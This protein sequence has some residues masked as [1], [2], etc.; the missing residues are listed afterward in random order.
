MI[1]K[2]ITANG[3]KGHHKF[4]LKVNEDRT[5]GNS[6]F[7]SFSF[8][9]SPIQT[10]WDWDASGV[11]YYI[12]IGDKEYSG[13]IY[14][15]NG[16]S[17]VTI[18][19]EGGIE[20]PHETDGTK[21]IDIAFNVVDSTSYSFTPG[22]AKASSTL[23]LTK[24]H[25]PPMLSSVSYKE[26]NQQLINVGVGDDYFVTN[27]SV[28]NVT[29]VATP[30]D[31]AQIT[32]YEIINGDKVY[33][34][35]TN[36]VEMNLQENSLEVVY[37]ENLKRNVAK[38]TIRLTDDLGGVSSFAYPYNYV[39]LYTK[40][41][42][43]KTSTTIKRKTGWSEQQQKNLV[44]TD[45]FGVLNFVGTCY[46]GNDVIGNN[47]TPKV[48]YKI[49]NGTEPSYTSLTTSNVANVTIKDH[50]LSNLLYT[51][52]YNYKIKITDTFTT[53][54]TTINVKSDRLPTGKSVWTEYPDRV[55]F[56]KATIGNLPIAD[57]VIEQGDNYIKWASGK[58][59]QWQKANM[60]P[61]NISYKTGEVYVGNVTFDNWEIP[62]ASAPERFVYS[63]GTVNANRN[64]WV[65]G[66]AYINNAFTAPNATSPGTVQLY[67]AWSA[68][69]Y[70]QIN[71]YAVGK[72]K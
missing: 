35:E 17:T 6:S 30:S 32:K 26:T 67:S 21:T 34:S 13:P 55:D 68:E 22:N 49:W 19:G 54:E 52:A 12:T 63:I 71:I 69:I 41:S 56:I 20:I 15:Y 5:S 51:S 39:I 11:N 62:F 24:L 16:S 72:W 10:G 60:N 46:K 50:E 33:S 57:F 53:T 27:L 23:E 8:V 7:I 65:G 58:L 42:I 64:I 59:E 43:E 40:P 66:P 28:K 37:D 36:I 48:E 4:T 45:N 3:S 29:I 2:T 44:L 70:G 47:N 38:L 1:T 9:L 25:E 61:L 31:D 18:A 14:K